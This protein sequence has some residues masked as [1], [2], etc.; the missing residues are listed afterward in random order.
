VAPAADADRRPDRAPLVLMA[1]ILGAAVAN[2]NLTLGVHLSVYLFAREGDVDA[3]GASLGEILR[4]A[5]AGLWPLRRR[6]RV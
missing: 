4:T 5:A 2:L 6:H 1:L 3:A